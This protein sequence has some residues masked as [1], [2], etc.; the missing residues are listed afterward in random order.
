[1]GG[2]DTHKL[3]GAAVQQVGSSAA[4]AMDAKN[5]A[6]RTKELAEQAV[7]QAK[8]ARVGLAVGAGDAEADSR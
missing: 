8:A 1:L 4:L 3:A 6:D 7:I 5:Q 2:N